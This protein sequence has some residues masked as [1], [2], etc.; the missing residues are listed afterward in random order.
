MMVASSF[1]LLATVGLFT[2][3][4]TAPLGTSTSSPVAAAAAAGV[5]VPLVVVGFVAVL[6]IVVALLWNRCVCVR[7]CM[8]VSLCVLFSYILVIV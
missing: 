5:V 3:P 6:V 7:A 4:G 2:P 8:H 1:P